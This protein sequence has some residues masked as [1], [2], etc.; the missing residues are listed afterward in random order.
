[1]SINPSG[2]N[3]TEHAVPEL[4]KIAMQLPVPPSHNRT[5]LSLDP[6]ASLEPSAENV[7]QRTVSQWPMRVLMWRPVLLPHNRMVPSPDA[8]ASLES[9]GENDT[10]FT[11]PV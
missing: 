8:D 2:E 9:L 4:R 5:D 3:A 10:E 7:T 1:M 6:E 11:E